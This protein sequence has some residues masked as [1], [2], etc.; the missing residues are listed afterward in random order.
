MATHSSVLAWESQ[1]WWSLVGCHLWGHTESDTTEVT[2][3][4]H[5]LEGLMQKSKLQYFGHLMWRADFLEKTLM[6]GKSE[7]RRRRG[8]QRTRWLDGIIDSM[9][10][11]LSKLWEMLKDREA[12]CTIV[13]SHRVG[14]DWAT[15]QPLVRFF[16]ETYFSYIKIAT[17]LLK[18][19]IYSH[20]F[21]FN[22]LS[23]FKWFSCRQCIVQFCF[24]KKFN[25][26]LMCILIEYL[27]Y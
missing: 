10:M 2:L 17:P 23:N 14:H 12:W 21:T 19:H 13:Y 15:E 1:G 26:T 4:Q 22:S 5:S 3:Q 20:P 16:S 11:R 7:G 27:H 9:S 18:S 25:V 6:L 8:K 24:L